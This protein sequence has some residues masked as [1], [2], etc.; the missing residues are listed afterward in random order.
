MN[1]NCRS[2]IGQFLNA[3]LSPSLFQERLQ[4]IEEFSKKL[5]LSALLAADVEQTAMNIAEQIFSIYP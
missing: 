2:Y 4:F 3:T 1:L 5:Q